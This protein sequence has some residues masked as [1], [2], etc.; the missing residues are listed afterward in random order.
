MASA[1]RL[2]ICLENSQILSRFAQLRSSGVRNKVP[3]LTSNM[4]YVTSTHVSR[5]NA[6]GLPRAYACDVS[7]RTRRTPW[8]VVWRRGPRHWGP[9]KNLEGF[10][11]EGWII[12]KGPIPNILWRTRTKV[13]EPDCWVRIKRRIA[14][15]G[16]LVHTHVRNRHA[17][18]PHSIVHLDSFTLF[19]SFIVNDARPIWRCYP[20]FLASVCAILSTWLTLSVVRLRGI[21][22][23]DIFEILCILRHCAFQIFQDFLLCSFYITKNR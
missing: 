8:G 15:V 5:A 14:M 20:L 23:H 12:I 22:Y 10:I 9:K 17:S 3:S 11:K 7:H 6:H 16:G 2:S 21:W 4:M 1:K 13:R 19:L 18:Q